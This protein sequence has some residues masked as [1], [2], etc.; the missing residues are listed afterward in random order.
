MFLPIANKS[1]LT[2]Q[3]KSLKKSFPNEKI[4]LSLPNDFD[5]SIINL[6]FIKK[7]NI[8]IIRTNSKCSLKKSILKVLKKINRNI[9]EDIKMLH[10]DNLLLEKISNKKDIIGIV[11]RRELYNTHEVI[12]IKNKE[13]IWSGYFNFSKKKLFI[14]CLT[15]SNS[16]VNAIKIYSS[17]K[18]LNYSLQKK[19]FDLGHV[20]TYFKSR[21]SIISSRHFNTI[22][23]SKNVIVKS[24][25]DKIKI[26]SEYLWLKNLPKNLKKYTPKLIEFNEFKKKYHNI[27]SSIYHLTLLMKYLFMVKIQFYFGKKYFQL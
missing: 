5:L 2:Y 15:K 22:K 12:N 17:K 6:E 26:K 11:P 3:I 19:W 4:Y 10:G 18:K 24:S 9:N 8:T 25:L 16:F 27:Q 14:K 7:N 23:V 21:S 1:L 13:F 20:N